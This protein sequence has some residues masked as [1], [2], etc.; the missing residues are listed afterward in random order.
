MVGTLDGRVIAITGAS[1]GIGLACATRLSRAGAAV[2]LSARRADRLDSIARDLSRAIAVPGDVTNEADMQ[3]LVA[4]AVETYGRLDVM[5][6]NAGAGFHG[7]LEET[8]PAVVRRLMDVNFVG[9]YLAARAAM[10]VFTRQR[11]GHL[12]IMSSIVGR[13]GIAGMTA[14]G[15]TKAAQ[16]GFAEALRTELLGT[17]IEVSTIFPVSTRTEFH[18]AMQRDYGHAVE[19]LGPKQTADSVAAAVEA[20]ILEPRPEVYPYAKS[21]ALAVIGVVAPRFTDKLVKKYGR[22]RNV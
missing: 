9:T 2:A 10:P 20:V 17:N 16:A 4:R 3:A 18:D 11:A 6:A 21:R 8:P 15:A 5:I 13:R 1:A 22:R 19:G 14:Y 7:T 12:I